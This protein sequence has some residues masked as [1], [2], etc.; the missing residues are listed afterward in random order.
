MSA[1]LPGQAFVFPVKPSGVSPNAQ[2]CHARVVRAICTP[3]CVAV[4]LIARGHSF[5]G[6]CRISQTS[7]ARC[8]VHG[9]STR[10]MVVS[11]GVA[12]RWSPNPSQNHVSR[13]TCNLS[14]AAAADHQTSGVRYQSTPRA[15]RPASPPARQPA[16]PPARQEVTV[17]RE[18]DPKVTPDVTPAHYVTHN[19]DLPSA[20]H[21]EPAKTCVCQESRHAQLVTRLRTQADSSF[22][23]RQDR[24]GDSAGSPCATV[25][26]RSR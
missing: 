12:D 24:K 7:T 21:V 2:A 1:A 3:E 15:N 19:G 16:S 10:D 11:T 22:H 18:T 23:P 5:T 17:S 4:E 20:F 13:E 26:L 9:N 6:N 14:T 8:K 25:R